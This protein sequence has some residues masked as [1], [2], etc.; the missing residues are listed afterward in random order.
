MCKLKLLGD[1]KMETSEL[2]KTNWQ[3]DYDHSKIGFTARHMVISEVD[4]QFNDYTLNLSGGK[5]FTD[6]KIELEIETK[7]VDTKNKDRDNHLRSADFF[8]AENFPKIK[9][10]SK[11]IEKVDDDE[12]K[13]TGDLTIKDITKPIELDVTYG[14]TIKD[15]FGNIRAGFVITGK[16]NRFDYGLKWNNLIESG[17][18]VVGKTIKINAPIEIVT[19]ADNNS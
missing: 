15:P 13:L 5:D 10:V 4:G 3:I 1:I 9:F 17:G 18:A 19:P 12:Y 8:D 14:G 11:S 16:L 2:T 7:S 6:S